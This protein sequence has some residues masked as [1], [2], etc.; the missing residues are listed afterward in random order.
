MYLTRTLLTV[1]LIVTGFTLG[2]CDSIDTLT[3]MLDTKKKLSGERKPVFPEGV[4]G[5]SMGVPP[6]MTKGYQEKQQEAQQQQPA[7]TTAQQ[8]LN[9]KSAEQSEA[10]QS[11]EAEK[12]KPKKVAKPKPTPAPLS[13]IHI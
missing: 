5:V 8:P 4:P 6:E 1:L 7:Q 11:K 12:P 3:N 9:Q 13:L 2:A 10:A